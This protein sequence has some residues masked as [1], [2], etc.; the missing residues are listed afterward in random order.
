MLAIVHFV[1]GTALGLLLLTQITDRVDN[2]TIGVLSGIWALGPDMNKFI[3]ELTFLH[4]SVWSNVFWF[5]PI[6][7]SL[8]T[9][10]PN[11]E[12]FMALAFLLFTVA[13]VERKA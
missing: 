12:A 10:F 1:I 13:L 6:I 3:P 7:D 9:A 4:D 5:H 8:E 11:A 2:S